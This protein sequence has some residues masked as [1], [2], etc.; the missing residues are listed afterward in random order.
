MW[1]RVLPVRRFA[2]RCG[3]ASLPL[4]V[5]GPGELTPGVSLA[6]YKAR[7]Q[8]L[9]NALPPKS[10]AIVCGSPIT[11][12]S[13]DV[14]FRFRHNADFNY[15]TGFP[16]EDAILLIS[17]AQPGQAISTLCVLPRDPS[18]EVWDGL[19]IG[20]E[21]ARDVYGFTRSDEL[22]N[23]GQHLAD[24]LR[25]TEHIFYDQSQD[26]PPKSRETL[27]N[28]LAKLTATQRVAS[29]VPHLHRLRIVK[30][31][32]E[33]SLMRKSCQIA[34]FAFVELMRATRA[35]VGEKD[36]DALMEYT[37]RTRGAARLSFPPVVA[38]GARACTLHYLANSG[39][40]ASGEMVFVDAGCEYNGYAS[41]ISRTWPV[42][43]TFSS[44]HREVYEAMLEVQKKCIAMCVADG[45]RSM[46]HIHFAFVR[47]ALQTLVDLKLVASLSSIDEMQAAFQRFCIHSIGHHLGM[48]VHDVQAVAAD[49]P[50]QPG[51]VVTI[52]PGLYIPD[53]PRLPADIRGLGFRIE[54]DVL[55]T[56]AA[57][58]VLTRDCPKT[59]DEIHAVLRD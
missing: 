48:D 22:Q 39:L 12:M 5:K 38:S 16:E 18:M 34:S 23:L 20:F 36:L 47:L 8:A 49:A 51:M 42:N 53:D 35:G 57:P 41:D 17:N 33:I 4:H 28:T 52:E 31:P 50:L 54:D 1:R 15:L 32:A 7:R 19:R 25:N 10:L 29:V 56:A 27:T 45:V 59:V 26:F 11:Y 9:A 6:E 24:N 40:L 21:Q 46:R 44:N 30:S 2:A 13:P 37:C 55:I 43:R 58:E 3:P 14:P